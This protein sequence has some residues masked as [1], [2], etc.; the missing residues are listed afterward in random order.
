MPLDRSPASSPPFSSG[1]ARSVRFGDLSITVDDDVLEPRGWTLLQSA[2][3]AELSPSLPAGPILELCSGAGQIGLAA[4]LATRRRLVQVDSS[5]HACALARHNAQVAGLSSRV[6]VRCEGLS[7]VRL[8][9]PAPLVLADPPYLPTERVADHPGDPVAAIDGGPDGLT[10][11]RACVR[12]IDAA[13]ADDGAALLQLYGA[14]QAREV[15]QLLPSSLALVEVREHDPHRAVALI[16]RPDPERN[17][18]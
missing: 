16:R 1:H 2:W 6:E 11:V 4:A 17:R 12:V 7:D 9:E 8:A 10:H 5:A 15:E 3:A 13:L 14:L 18:R